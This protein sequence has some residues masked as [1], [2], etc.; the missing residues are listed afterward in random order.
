MVQQRDNGNITAIA[1]NIHGDDRKHQKRFSQVKKI[2]LEIRKQPKTWF[3]LGDISFKENDC[4]KEHTDEINRI[5][6]SKFQ[7][8]RRVRRFILR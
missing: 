4:A 2:L 7:K 8:R 5:E 6:K 1:K 3:P